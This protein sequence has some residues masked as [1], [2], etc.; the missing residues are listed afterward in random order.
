MGNCIVKC[1]VSSVLYLHT[2]TY[3]YDITIL[4]R[5]GLC[6]AAINRKPNRDLQIEIY[7]SH[8]GSPQLAN[9]LPSAVE[10]PILFSSLRVLAS[11]LMLAAF[12]S[13]TYI[14]KEKAFPETLALCLINQNCVMETLE[15][16]LRRPV[17]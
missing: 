2:Y 3:I 7:L 14:T 13:G 4:N 16:S 5:L 9:L 15:W 8:D 6:S 11:L 17:F 12:G 1:K 10:G